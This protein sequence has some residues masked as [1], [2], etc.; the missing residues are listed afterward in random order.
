MKGLIIA[1]HANLAAEL[2]TACEL[3]IGPVRSAGQFQSSVRMVS[4]GFVNCSC[5]QSRKLEKM[6]K[7]F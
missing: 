4:T 2:L 3:I 5:R 6:E 1:S 7:V